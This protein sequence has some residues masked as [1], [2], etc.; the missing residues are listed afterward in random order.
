MT[1]N[2]SLLQNFQPSHL[3]L[4]PFP[5]IHIENA[6]PQ[7]LYDQLAD[8]YPESILG[9]AVSGFKDFRYCQH[10]FTDQHVTPLW[11]Q[12]IDFHS[13]K[14]YKDQ[15]IQALEPGMRQYYN[16]ITDKYLTCETILRNQGKP[17]LKAALEVQFVMNSA[18]TEKIRTPHL[19]QGREL[20]ACLF[21][22][23]KPEDVSDGG[24]LIIYKKNHEDFRFQSGRLAPVEHI[25]EA[26][27]VPYKPNSLVI[28][29][30]TSDSI[31]GVSL[32]NNA[33]VF[34]RY[35]NIDCHV[36]EKLFVLE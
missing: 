29:L 28:F 35:V 36:T 34:R 5:Y 4:D 31:H 10:E 23:R 15:V 25:L 24:D 16:D 7:Q 8:Q 17:K 14:A 30:N 12:F 32:R 11:K 33:S 20:F 21:Y 1:T 9:G 6:L 13:S 3:H 18:D 2:F 22:M 27:R 26:G 19:D